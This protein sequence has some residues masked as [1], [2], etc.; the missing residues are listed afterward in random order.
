M[1]VLPA[2]GI[3]GANASGKTNLLRALFDMRDAVRTSFAEWATRPGVPRQPFKLDSTAADETTLY[4]VDLMLGASP[5]RY[6]Y[7]FELSDERVEAE[8]LHAYPEGERIVWF[9][10]EADR[11]EAEGLPSPS[12]FRYG[13][14]YSCR[15]HLLQFGH[16]SG[17]RSSSARASSLETGS[18]V[19][20]R[21]RWRPDC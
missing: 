18:P 17:A 6:T 15:T 1:S 7:G 16:A 14:Q 20:S 21:G 19:Y 11:P 9:D 10:R 4:E 13:P 3:F 12:G 5:V 8:W 2:I